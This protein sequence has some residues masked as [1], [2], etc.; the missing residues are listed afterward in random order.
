[1]QANYS[2]EAKEK[3]SLTSKEGTTNAD[4]I[5]QTVQSDKNDD[6]CIGIINENAELTGNDW[7]DDCHEDESAFGEDTSQPVE[8]LYCR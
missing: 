8:L 5:V 6:E 2:T 3:H 7:S 1:M 4:V